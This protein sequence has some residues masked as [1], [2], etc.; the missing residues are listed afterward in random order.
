MFAGYVQQHWKNNAFFGY[1]FLNGVNP[2][3]IKRCDALPSNFP[4][5]NDMVLTPGQGSLTD[6][7]KVICLNEMGNMFI[8][9][10]HIQ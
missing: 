9:I 7:M 4:V 10:Y 1:Q 6:E 5:T 2:M 3:L 8:F